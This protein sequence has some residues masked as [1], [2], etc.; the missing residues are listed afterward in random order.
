MINPAPPNSPITQTFAEHERRRK[1]NGWR[2]YNGGLDF[3]VPT[4]T[5]VKAAAAGTITKAGYD[6]TGYGEH[7]RI[8]HESDYLSLYG[9]LASY[10]VR[11][12][13]HVEAGEVIGYSDNTGNSTGPHLHFELRK[14][15]LPVDPE[16]LLQPPPTEQPAGQTFA[17][18]AQT[19][20]VRAGPGTQYSIICQLKQGDQVEALSMSGEVWIELGQNEWAAMVYGQDVLMRPA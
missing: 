12:G 3:A 13:Q 19:L 11:I 2:Y 10:C 4:G 7:V 20:N 18:C 9:H 5:P 16:P 6:A 14:N 17:V 8:Q 1:K 15:G